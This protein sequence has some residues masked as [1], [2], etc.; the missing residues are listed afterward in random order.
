IAATFGDLFDLLKG[1]VAE[2]TAGKQ[3]PWRSGTPLPSVETVGAERQTAPSVTNAESI[4][5]TSPPDSGATTKPAGTAKPSEVRSQ[6][7]PKPLPIQ[8][9]IETADRKAAAQ[10]P[11]QPKPPEQVRASVEKAEPV[12]T[13]AKHDTPPPRVNEQKAVIGNGVNPGPVGRE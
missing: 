3:H 12:S 2:D 4:A 8:P 7:E 11:T 5:R 10:M 13:P 9:S 1:R 6:V